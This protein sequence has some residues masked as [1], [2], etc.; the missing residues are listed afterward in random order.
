MR[1]LC[2]RARDDAVVK[3]ARLKPRV[4]ALS[5]GLV[6]PLIAERLRGRQAVERNRKFLAEHPYCGCCPRQATEVDHKVPLHLGGL[7]AEPNLQG[8]CHDC[9][10]SKT[11]AEQAARAK[12]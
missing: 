2:P 7:D 4:P 12:G 5:I 6:T 8:L 11:S 9:H 3:L 10:A 1:W